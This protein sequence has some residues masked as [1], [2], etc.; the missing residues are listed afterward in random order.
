MHDVRI[1]KDWLLHKRIIPQP[2][3]ARLAN[4]TRPNT[5]PR[6][7]SF[8]DAPPTQ[9]G[10]QAIITVI[11][12]QALQAIAHAR[13]ARNA[14]Q[15]AEARA[16]YTQAAAIYRQQDDQLAY[17][18]TLRHIADILQQEANPAEARPL[19]E[20][21]LD[22]YRRNLA[23]KLLDLANTIRPYALLLE[24]QGDLAAALALWEEAR[25]LYGALRLEEGVLE[26]NQHL[27]ALRQK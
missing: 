10:T 18:H 25:T 21:A 26:C 17:A 1:S 24:Q 16:H 23:T 9:P 15:F 2:N 6:F 13:L 4:S 20:Q 8:P 12:T 27:A 7:Q 11:T 19:Y 22:L 3:R 5:S 14:G